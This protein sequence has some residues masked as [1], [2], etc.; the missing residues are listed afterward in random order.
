MEIDWLDFALQ[1]STLKDEI[2]EVLRNNVN[3][4]K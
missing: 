3:A 1:H 2:R 4:A